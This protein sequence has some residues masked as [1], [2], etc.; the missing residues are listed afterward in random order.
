MVIDI[1]CDIPTR[2]AVQR[3]L[4]SVGSGDTKGMVNYLNLFGPKWAAEVGMTMEEFE[5][6]K[7]TLGLAKLWKMVKEKILEKAMT[8]DQFVKMLD[9][10]GVE[11]ACIGTGSF[12]SNE[13]TASLARK[14]KTKFI[15]WFRM[16]PRE[17]MDG[18]RKLEQGVKELG[19]KGFVVSPF[20]EKIYVN[21]KKYY[22]FYAK[23]VELGLPIRA[24]TSM[25]YAT[26]RSMD[27]G[28]PVYLDE[29]ACDFPEL[30]IIAGLG[31][32]P[33][34][35]ELIGV[36]RRHQNVYIDLAAHRPK[37][38]KNPGSGFEM[39]LQFGNTVLQDRILFASSWMNLS[40]PMK[41]IIQETE[42]LTR[43]EEVKKKWMYGNAA[44]ILEIGK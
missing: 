39:F 16:S 5:E 33:W 15:P 6:G 32:W 10:A 30:T 8:D 29:V 19:F 18:V 35:P 1:E 43:N 41:Q 9:E 3:D 23:C 25:N 24:H 17:G 31:G 40:I 4:E 44:R 14:Y 26:D 11:Y 36:A 22:P 12:A 42:E 37:Y 38:I 13:H 2:E 21:D 34:V 7:K 20:R 28:R 27:L